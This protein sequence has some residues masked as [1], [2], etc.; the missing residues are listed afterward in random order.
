[1]RSFWMQFQVYFKQQILKAMKGNTK[2]KLSHLFT[3]IVSP[4]S[5]DSATILTMEMT[6]CSTDDLISKISLQRIPSKRK[7]PWRWQNKLLKFDRF[8]F[9]DPELIGK[10]NL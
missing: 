9:N 5:D 2:Q 8:V 10:K 3:K 7:H 6:E 1:M 4:R